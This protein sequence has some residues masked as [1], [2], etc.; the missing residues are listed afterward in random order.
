MKTLLLLLTLT[1]TWD[2]RIEAER[3]LAV[4]RHAWSE[5][6]H[7]IETE[8]LR[9]GWMYFRADPLGDQRQSVVLLLLGPLEV[10]WRWS[11]GI[12]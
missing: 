10:F 6:I 9:F 8:D 7:V 4:S 11:N 12:T 3:A 1:S 5:E 2:I